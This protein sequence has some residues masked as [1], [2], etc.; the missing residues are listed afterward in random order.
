MKVYVALLRAINVGGTG[1]LPMTELRELCEGCGFKD[2]ATYIQSG[3]V[4]FRSKLSESGVKRALESALAR[5]MGKPFGA[6]IRTGAEL[7]AVLGGNPFTQASPA[8]VLVLFLDAPPAPDCLDEVV[9]PGGEELA[10]RGR[11]LYMF[12]PDGMGQSKLKI[13]LQKV[14]TARNLNTVTQ[15][16]ALARAL[17]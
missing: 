12:F 10:L 3:N 15:V 4:V 13:P 8:R 6:L 11:E 7:E 16:A 2:V 1:K 14:G 17:A 5:K 9:I